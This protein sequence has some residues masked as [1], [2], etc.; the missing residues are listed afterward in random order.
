MTQTPADSSPVRV[1]VVGVGALGRHHARILAGMNGVELV[2]VVDPNAAQGQAVA[3]QHQTRWAASYDEILDSCDAL[4][5]VAPTFLHHQIATRCLQAGKDLLVEKPLTANVTQAEQLAQLAL[6]HDCILQV[7]HIERFNPAFELL[8]ESLTSVPRYIRAE[9]L[10][11][12]PFRSLDI[13]AIHDLMIH[14]IELVLH[15]TGAMPVRCEAVGSR[16]MGAHEDM[17]Q[18]RLTFPDGCIADIT[19]SRVNPE[20]RRCLQVWS[21][22]ES[23]NVDLQTRTLTIQRPT[24]ALLKG[25]AMED[26]MRAGEDVTQLKSQVFT[27]FIEQEELQAASTDALTAEL[28]EF[29]QAVRQREQPRVTGKTGLQAVQVAEQILQ[30]LLFNCVNARSFEPAAKVA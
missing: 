1:A 24:D 4:S 28:S 9:R 14:D 12:F 6:K 27:E 17:V 23:L 25:P 10:S 19:A 20:A 16:L 29:M 8:C 22:T 21:S 30:A 15:L 26:R 5:I 7:G 18:A 13:G 2:A 3:Q 11:P